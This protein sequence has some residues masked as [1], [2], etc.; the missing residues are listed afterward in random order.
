MWKVDDFIWK[1]YRHMDTEAVNSIGVDLTD[2]PAA[3]CSGH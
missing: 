1:K 3:Y 2:R